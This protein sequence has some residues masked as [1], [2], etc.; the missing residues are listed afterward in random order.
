MCPLQYTLRG[1]LCSV[2]HWPNA[3]LVG[4]V[5]GAPSHTW[6]NAFRNSHRISTFTR[7]LILNLLIPE[8]SATLKGMPLM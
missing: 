6:L 3:P 4:D 8:R 5:L 1:E 2:P 7:S